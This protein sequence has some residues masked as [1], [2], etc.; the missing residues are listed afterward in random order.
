MQRLKREIPNILTLCNLFCGCLSIA[1]T[2]E[3]RT[4][5]AAVFILVA[6]VFDLFDGMVA[7]LLGVAGPLV[8]F[9]LYKL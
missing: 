8:S 1:C 5:W 9:G 3:G 2:F 7:R 6:A 4:E